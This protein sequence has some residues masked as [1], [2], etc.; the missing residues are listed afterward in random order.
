VLDLAH[1]DAMTSASIGCRLWA[2]L[3][4]LLLLLLLLQLLLQFKLQLL[5]LQ[6]QLL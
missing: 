1:A 4:Q 5:L 6:L 2:A 3:Q